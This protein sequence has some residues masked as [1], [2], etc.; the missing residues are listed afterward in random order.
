MS[1][2]VGDVVLV[3]WVFARGVPGIEDP[4]AGKRVRAWVISTYEDAR[5]APAC[6][7]LLEKEKRIL[8]FVPTTSLAIVDRVSPREM[9]K[10]RDLAEWL[11]SMARVMGLQ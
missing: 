6:D 2:Q 4:F 9:W 5:G 1:V 3:P 10:L 11:A 7:V 8:G